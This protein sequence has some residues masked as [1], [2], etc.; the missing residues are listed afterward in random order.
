M[1]V[2]DF[3]VQMAL[4]VEPDNLELVYTRPLAFHQLLNFFAAEEVWEGSVKNEAGLRLRKAANTVFGTMVVEKEGEEPE[5]LCIF[6][7]ESLTLY[8]FIRN[9]NP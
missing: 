2:E 5:A 7:F 1:T 8:V 4:S 6:V 9:I 3:A